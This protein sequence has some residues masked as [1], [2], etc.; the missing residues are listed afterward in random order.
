MKRTD[1]KLNWDAVAIMTECSELRSRTMGGLGPSDYCHLLGSIVAN[2]FGCR[3]LHAVLPASMAGAPFRRSVLT[4]LNDLDIRRGDKA[5][6][7]SEIDRI[8]GSPTAPSQHRAGYASD[9]VMAGGDVF[10]TSADAKALADIIMLEAAEPPL[11][12]GIFGAWG[13]GKS[14]LIAELKQEIERQVQFEKERIERNLNADDSLARVSGV[15]QLEFNA[16]S[17]ADSENLWASLTAELFDQ[18]AA[19]GSGPNATAIGAKLVAEVAAR[20]GREAGELTQAKIQLEE[21]EGEIAA[22]EKEVAA[23][24]LKEKST[25][26]SAVF[27]TFSEMIVDSK[28]EKGKTEDKNDADASHASDDEDHSQKGKQSA[29]ALKV[30]RE[31]L[32]ID[33]EQ[34][35]RTLVEKYAET[36]S[37]ITELSVFAGAWLKTPS[38]KRAGL[39]LAIIFLAAVTVGIGLWRLWNPLSSLLGAWT[40]RLAAIGTVAAPFAYLGLAIIAPIARGF[41]LV[42]KKFIS[43]RLKN[44]E[45]LIAAKKKLNASRKAKD[46]A[47]AVIARSE[48]IVRQYGEIGDLGSPP[49]ALMLNYLLKD[50]ADVAYLR[51]RLGTLGAVRRCFDQLNHIIERMKGEDSASEV[52]RIVIYIDDLDRCNEKQVVQ[53]LEAIHLMLAFPCFVVVAAVD[54][55]WLYSALKEEHKAMK[56]EDA[57]IDPA[58]YL[59]KIFQVPF[60]VQTLKPSRDPSSGYVNY[61]RALLRL[62]PRHATEAPEVEL[63]EAEVADERHGEFPRLDPKRPPIVD[64]D[65][66]VSH[67]LTL[68]PEEIRL[69]EF[70]QPVAA[71]S[72]RAVKRM[73][74]IYRLIRVAIPEHLVEDYLKDGEHV[75]PYWAIILTLALET[76]MSTREMGTLVSELRAI[77]QDDFEAIQAYAHGIVGETTVKELASN[78]DKVLSIIRSPGG[79]RLDTALTV[80]DQQGISCAQSP[81][82]RALDVVGRYSFRVG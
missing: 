7:K 13:S 45:T 74:N 36:G 2:P 69:F 15:M 71:R 70:M 59:E 4:I 22:A 3:A 24:A 25:L 51:E 31:T 38:A 39:I 76:G 29:L 77:D 35:G 60:W 81:F 33:Q 66:G 21:S 12:I 23:A 10:G 44:A 80:L 41:G 65:L 50:S 16:W 37:A 43:A 67:Q 52:Q 53:V 55:R 58:D 62:D 18:I 9:R 47:K 63:E 72:P 82:M 17:F 49:P 11:A 61:L 32:L 8:D 19:G 42:R 78:P 5:F 20:T 14:T 6:W 79:E 40:A 68:S 34:S 28:S 26:A 73:V 54:V 56:G 75:P 48:P 1:V 27:D 64:A 46:D 57:T 30:V